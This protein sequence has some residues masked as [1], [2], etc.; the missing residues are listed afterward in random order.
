MARLWMALADVHN[1][2]FSQLV[3]AKMSGVSSGWRE[4][5][6]DPNR[7]GDHYDIEQGMRSAAGDQLLL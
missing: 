4:R 3:T 1:F 7:D 6:A 2:P 5:V